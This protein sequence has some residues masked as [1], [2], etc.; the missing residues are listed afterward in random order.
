[1][2][3][4]ESHLELLHNFSRNCMGIQTPVCMEGFIPEE[5]IRACKSQWYLTL[6]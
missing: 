6:S 3:A 4:P 5:K 1:M 2:V